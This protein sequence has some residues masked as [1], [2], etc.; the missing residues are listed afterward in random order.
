MEEGMTESI[1]GWRMD[2]GVID[3]SWLAGGQGTGE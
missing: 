2:Y 1:H 3:K